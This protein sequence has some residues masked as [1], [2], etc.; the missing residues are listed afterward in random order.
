MGIYPEPDVCSG[1]LPE[2]MRVSLTVIDPAPDP[3]P[4]PTTGVSPLVVRLHYR[5]HLGSSMTSKAFTAAGDITLGS[6]TLTLADGTAI[7]LPGE[8]KEDTW[9]DPSATR[10]IRM[11]PPTTRPATPI[12]NATPS[13][14]STT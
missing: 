14:G 2:S 4:D 1:P 3:D 9:Y 6:M 5:D 10:S 12:T 11:P 8:P 7:V 13:A